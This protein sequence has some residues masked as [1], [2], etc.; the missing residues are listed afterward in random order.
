MMSTPLDITLR[1][2]HFS[3]E[4]LINFRNAIYDGHE[5]SLQ[6]FRERMDE[7]EK[8]EVLN[9]CINQKMAIQDTNEVIKYKIERY[10]YKEREEVKR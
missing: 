6:R 1:A 4:D 3:L 7:N 2:K 8:C 9:I 5:L 10:G